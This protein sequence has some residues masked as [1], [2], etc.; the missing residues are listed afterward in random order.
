MGVIVVGVDG[1]EPAAQAALAAARLA[2]ALDAELRVVCAYGNYE[3]ERITEDRDLVFT[4]VEPA[5][6]VAEQT[7]ARLLNVYPNLDVSAQAAGGK[8]ADALLEVATSVDADMIVVGNKRVQG[9]SRILGS[10]ATEV[11]RKAQ[12]D[13]HIVYTHARG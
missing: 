12:C 8:P 1:S 11:A 10:I 13:L 4:T 2:V 9:A 6:E 3:V 7:I 5:T